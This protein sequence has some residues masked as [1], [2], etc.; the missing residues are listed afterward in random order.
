MQHVPEN[1][2]YYAAETDREQRTDNTAYCSDCCRTHEIDLRPLAKSSARRF[3][4]FFHAIAFKSLQRT[5]STRSTVTSTV[6]RYLSTATNLLFRR[7]EAT[8]KYLRATGNYVKRYCSALTSVAELRRFKICT[9]PGYLRFPGRRFPRVDGASRRY[10]PLYVS[11]S[12]I[13]LPTQNP[14][15]D[16]MYLQTLLSFFSDDVNS[17]VVNFFFLINTYLLTT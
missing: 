3:V 11:G 4:L 16:Y 10:I 6:A 14:S 2:M 9:F 15:L 5:L 12:Q 8:D 1:R 17:D 13:F 7:D